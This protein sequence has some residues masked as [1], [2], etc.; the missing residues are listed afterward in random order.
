MTLTVGQPHTLQR[1]AT[2]PARP[3]HPVTRVCHGIA[4]MNGTLKGAKW[5]VRNPS[6]FKRAVI[7][8]FKEEHAP[9]ASVP[10]PVPVKRNIVMCLDSTKGQ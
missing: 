10:S 2:V 6:L 8:R 1:H 7:A 9:Q 5:V 3:L 4:Q